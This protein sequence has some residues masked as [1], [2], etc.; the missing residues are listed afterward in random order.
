MLV[1]DVVVGGGLRGEVVSVMAMVLTIGC[2]KPWLDH[3]GQ[4]VATALVV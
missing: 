2:R 3:K 1:P 4:A